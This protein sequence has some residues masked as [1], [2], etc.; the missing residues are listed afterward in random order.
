MRPTLTKD[1]ETKD[2]L[3]YYWLKDELLTFC[4]NNHIPTTGSKLEITQNICRYLDG[5]TVQSTK[6]IKESININKDVVLTPEAIIPKNYRNDEMHRSFFKQ[7]IGERFKFNVAFMNWMKENH[8][9]KYSEAIQVW[10]LIEEDK[11]KG[12]KIEILPQFEYNQYTRDFYSNN[13]GKTKKDLIACWN[14]KKSLPGS[15]KYED[16]DLAILKT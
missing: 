14:Y 6:K 2:F 3:K 16:S 13:P 12:K 8:G 11:R 1:L 10:L 15:H 5:V 9:K 7:Q 4:K